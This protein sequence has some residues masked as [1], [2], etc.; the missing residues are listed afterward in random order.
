MAKRSSRQSRS[1]DGRQSRFSQSH[2]HSDQQQTEQYPT[3]YSAPE[4]GSVY[5]HDPAEKNVYTAQ[6]VP[7]RSRSNPSERS[8][9][10][11]STGGFLNRGTDDERPGW[12][13][14]DDTGIPSPVHDVLS[15]SGRGLCGP[16]QR[17]IEDKMGEEFGDVR[18]HTGQDAAQACEEVN[19]RAFTA[20]NHIVF[21]SGEFDPQSPEGKYVLAHEMAHVKQQTGGALS[22]LP[23][24]DSELEV[25]PDPALEREADEAATE[26]LSGEDDPQIQC[27]PGGGAEVYV[28]R[29]PEDKVFHALAM[30]SDENDDGDVGDFRQTQNARRIQFLEDTAKEIL[31]K[32][33]TQDSLSKKQSL[34]EDGE[35]ELAERFDSEASLKSEIEELSKSINADLDQVALTDDQRDKLDGEIDPSKLEKVSW[36]VIKS[37]LTMAGIVPA[38]AMAAYNAGEAASDKSGDKTMGKAREKGKETYKRSRETAKKV[39]ENYPEVEWDD[40]KEWWENATGDLDQ[41]AQEVKEQIM[42][43]EW[44]DDKEDPTGVRE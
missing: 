3:W 16:I 34:E 29:I 41:R 6:T 37:L 18:I 35:H 7:G 26:A 14:E 40:I 10:G 36:T 44:Y 19:A 2:R 43:G 27:L 25:D 22:L 17:D 21:N 11:F 13:E 5:Q 24:A 30:F 39:K 8:P 42:K 38:L 32:E 20:G 15:S 28:Q 12:V 1:D 33:E 23:Q 31:E 4:E 9:P